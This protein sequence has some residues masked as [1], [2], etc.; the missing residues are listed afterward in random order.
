[1]LGDCRVENADLVPQALSLLEA[2][3]QLLEK[4][5]RGDFAGMARQSQ[6]IVRRPDGEP[7][8][9]S[10]AQEKLWYQSQIDGIPPLY[11]ESI[12]V[13][14]SGPLDVAALERSL[15]EIIRRHEIWR[16]SY[17]SVNGV[18][19]Q[20]IHPAATNFPLPVVDL[21]RYPEAEGE[22]R[23]LRLATEQARQSFDLRAGPLLRATLVR[24]SDQD[25]QLSLVAHLSI[26]D[27]VSVYQ[28]F[29]S[30]LTALYAAF[31]AGKASPL[32][33][34]PVQYADYAYWQRNWLKDAQLG[35]QLAYWRRQLSG[36][37]PVLRWPTYSLVLAIRPTYQGAIQTF[38]LS[39]RLTDALKQFSRLAGVTLFTTLMASFTSLLHCYT[40]QVDLIVETPSPAGRK[41]SEVQS[42][43][44]YFLNPVILRMNLDGNP[45]FNDLL[46]R[47]KSVIAGAL[48]YDDVPIEVLAGE[49]QLTPDPSRKPFF[50]MALSLQ[51]QTPDSAAEWQVTSMDADSGGSPWDFYLAFIDRPNGILGRVQYNP[52]VFEPAAIVHTLEDLNTVMQSALSD[53]SAHVLDLLTDR[54]E[55][56]LNSYE[57]EL[58]HRT[59]ALLTR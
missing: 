36:E 4:F 32:P 38:A 48:S 29:P 27:G 50:S 13:R 7:A 14:R 42:L 44:G 3:R 8:P 35:A 16:T 17:D 51:P 59:S 49:L 12:T 25:Y 43:L 1:M 57:K 56:T 21:R 39:Q 18:P 2:K 34:L 53:S 22:Q 47:T 11:N 6:A 46:Q 55:P 19:V 54:R 41:R 5:S 52:N 45:T 23:A 10:V 33:E 20:L 37:L 15:A 31:S 30:E 58:S 40:R 28:V 26:V 24:M 9:L